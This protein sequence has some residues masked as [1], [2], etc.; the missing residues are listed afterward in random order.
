[1]EIL[2]S[3]NQGDNKEICDAWGFV[4]YP[5]DSINAT[6]LNSDE[7]IELFTLEPTRLATALGL[8]NQIIAGS[9]GSGKTMLLRA[10]D[11]FYKSR[12]IYDLCV[13]GEA[14]VFPVYMNGTDIIITKEEDQSQQLI[15]WIG[16]SLINKTRDFTKALKEPYWFESVVLNPLIKFSSLTGSDDVENLRIFLTKE[17][18]K[19]IKQHS[20]G[21]VLSEFSKNV[22]ELIK[23]EEETY[24]NLDINKLKRLF[25]LSIGKRC[26]RLMLLIDEINSFPNEVYRAETGEMSIFEG[27]I[28]ILRNQNYI[29]YS[30]AVEPGTRTD[31]IRD[32]RYGDEIN[33]SVYLTNFEGM[34][35]RRDYIYK[36]LQSYFAYAKNHKRHDFPLQD[37]FFM[38]DQSCWEGKE[39]ELVD[40]E[41]FDS[42][43]QL[44]LGSYG[45]PRQLLNLVKRALLCSI[46][47]N[48]SD[49]IY[50][51]IVDADDVRTAIIHEGERMAKQH[52]SQQELLHNITMKCRED[53]T[54]R[55]HCSYSKIKCFLTG[56]DPILRVCQTLG[57]KQ[58]SYEFHFAYTLYDDIPT[59]YIR[60][61]HTV[62]ISR[63]ILVS[64]WIANTCN[65][66]NLN[67]SKERAIELE[68]QIKSCRAGKKYF[69]D[70]ELL[71]KDILGYLFV[72]PLKGVEPQIT[73]FSG[74]QRRDFILSNPGYG[75][76]FWKKIYDH[77]KSKYVL[78]DAKNN[79]EGVSSENLNQ[80]VG[81]LQ[82][83]IGNVGI[84]LCRRL[85]G[86]SSKSSH[87]KLTMKSLIKRLVEIYNK[88]NNKIILVVTDE[89]II[90]M[91]KIKSEGKNPAHILE[92][93]YDSFMMR[94]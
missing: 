69:H 42:L 21:G 35:Q 66:N 78:F 83:S 73:N 7:L 39:S 89:D 38:L 31:V 81:Y 84:I 28:N 2:N 48:H 70:Y 86:L 47:R 56:S 76:S 60:G 33:L 44:I 53:K 85:P 87:G 16:E 72:P 77:D 67:I 62:S 57:K 3:F 90:K 8:K 71:C 80:I 14:D 43:E 17:K 6:Q 40:D 32:S 30:I 91:L 52:E 50:P 94:V 12:F 23:K 24:K 37:Y 92:R 18:D 1:M 10:L 59:H 93:L 55:F 29:L 54:F 64:D 20:L 61:T 27:F 45:L 88:Q 36:M 4:R 75:H 13:K 58:L 22:R 19:F 46:R 11:S 82:Q 41:A 49:V 65:A 34:K 26:K 63:S 5:F 25:A 51:K 74:T 68:S 9:R 15:K 79:V